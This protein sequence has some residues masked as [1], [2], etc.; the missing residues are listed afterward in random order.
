V[1]T[2]KATVHIRDTQ[3]VG[4]QDFS[5]NCHVNGTTTLNAWERA[6]EVAESLVG[7][8]LPATCTVYKISVSNPDVVNGS[9]SLPA[10]LVGTRSTTGS[11]LPGWNVVRVQFSIAEGVRPHTFFLRM[12]LTEGDVVGQSL[13]IPTGDA[14]QSFIDAFLL[15]G[16]NC[17]KDGFPFVVGAYS[18]FV[19]MRQ[20]G[21]RRRTRPG[22]KRGWVPA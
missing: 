19:A 5:F 13:E 16:A 22:F 2:Y 6:N 20:M 15:T 9:L 17:D 7:T 11:T 12:G 21:W 1:A 14:V 18:N 3:L 10:E 8:V 4:D